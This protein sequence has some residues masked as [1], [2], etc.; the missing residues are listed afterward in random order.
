MP[1]R[2]GVRYAVVVLCG[3]I[4]GGRTVDLAQVLIELRRGAAHP[5]PAQALRTL[6]LVDAAIVIV[7]LVI[8]ALVWSLLRPLPAPATEA[9]GRR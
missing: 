6:A 3:V 9:R 7:S 8:A 4:A 1:A 5:A 2:T